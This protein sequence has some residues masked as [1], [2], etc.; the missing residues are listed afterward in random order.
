MI[1]LI[2]MFYIIISENPQQTRC[3]LYDSRTYT[4]NKV[5]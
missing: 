3:F 2:A 5:W 1:A 4:S